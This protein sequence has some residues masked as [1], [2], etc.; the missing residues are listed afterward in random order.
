MILYY[1]FYSKECADEL[2]NYNSVP[3]YKHYYNSSENK[4][5]CHCVIPVNLSELREK[6]KKQLELKNLEDYNDEKL[7]KNAYEV[8]CGAYHRNDKQ[9]VGLI[10]SYS[11][12][13]TFT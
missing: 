3:V 2:L 1:G 13:F 4:L 12:K 10:D 8:A 9:F 5:L 11:H 6:R 7:L